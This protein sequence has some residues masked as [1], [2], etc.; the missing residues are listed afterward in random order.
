MFYNCVWCGVSFKVRKDG[1]ETVKSKQNV[2]GCNNGRDRIKAIGVQV[3]DTD[4]LDQLSECGNKQF[5]EE[6]LR[7]IYE[8]CC[9]PTPESYRKCVQAALTSFLY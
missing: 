6:R 8:V 9:I 7:R 5:D 1:Y 4:Q 2:H 3:L